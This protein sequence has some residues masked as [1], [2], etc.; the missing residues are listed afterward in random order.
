MTAYQYDEAANAADV[1]KQ[2]YEVKSTKETVEQGK[3]DLVDRINIAYNQYHDGT[4][5]AQD[6]LANLD[7]FERE[8]ITGKYTDLLD[9]MNKLTDYVRED[10]VYGKD[11]SRG[12]NRIKGPG[13]GTGGYSVDP[14]TGEISGS[15]G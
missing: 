4:I 14:I 12:G 2:A 3:N 15:G 1:N 10:V 13:V 6:F 9:N 11:W 8:A 7:A 5:T